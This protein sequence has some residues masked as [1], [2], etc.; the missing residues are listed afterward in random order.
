MKRLYAINIPIIIWSIVI[1]VLAPG[2]CSSDPPSLAKVT[3]GAGGN[4]VITDP[5]ILW[6][7]NMGDMNDH[8]H[9]LNIPTHSFTS[10]YDVSAD[11]F[12]CGLY[13]LLNGADFTPYNYLRFTVS[14]QSNT[15][16]P[17]VFKIEIQDNDGTSII[18]ATQISTSPQQY[19]LN[20]NQV[21]DL[22][23]NAIRQI[24]IIYERFGLGG[25]GIEDKG[26]DLS[27]TLN[28]EN[29]RFE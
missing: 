4:N 5:N 8:T 16:N 1:L 23:K 12:W 3:I 6:Y 18:Y 10:T 13:M 17:E 28:F 9:V 15:E 29:F 7:M 21:T 25:N 14:A 2:V 11:P 20:L 27:G 22:N 19:S 24:N 26:G